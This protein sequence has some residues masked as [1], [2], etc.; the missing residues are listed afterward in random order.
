MQKITLTVSDEDFQVLVRE[1]KA[2]D[3][4]ILKLKSSLIQVTI[5]SLPTEEYPVDQN[6]CREDGA[7]FVG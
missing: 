6:F 2:G 5:L 1:K 4:V 3:E 7:M